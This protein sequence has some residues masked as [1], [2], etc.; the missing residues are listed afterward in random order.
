M[1]APQ[2]IAFIVSSCDER[3]S[4]TKG[5]GSMQDHVVLC[6]R[7]GRHN[8]LSLNFLCIVPA[9]PDNLRIGGV[10][11]EA[12]DAV[13]FDS[14]ELICTGSGNNVA[15]CIALFVKVKN[16]VRE[17]I[18]ID[19]DILGNVAQIHNLS[20]NEVELVRVLVDF[21]GFA[22][23]LELNG[24]AFCKCSSVRQADAVLAGEVSGNGKDRISLVLGIVLLLFRELHLKEIVTYGL[25][26][27]GKELIRI[28]IQSLIDSE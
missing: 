20:A 11:Q 27:I 22:V 3:I 18:V 15:V 6:E 13:T 16:V 26:L 9:F 1:P 2:N 5:L 10:L 8:A 21:N 25:L 19:V 28:Y 4:R 24:K 12:Y 23:L 7:N 17:R 14:L